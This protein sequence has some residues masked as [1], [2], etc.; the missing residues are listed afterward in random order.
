MIFAAIFMLIGFSL[1]IAT[2]FELNDENKT[3]NDMSLHALEMKY[4]HH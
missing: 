1:I 4:D 2:F 3:M